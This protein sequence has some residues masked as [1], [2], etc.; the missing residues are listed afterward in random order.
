RTLLVMVAAL[1]LT[2]SAALIACGTSGDSS[3]GVTVSSCAA[4]GPEAHCREN[5]ALAPGDY[6]WKVIADDG[7]DG[8]Q[9]ESESR[10]FTVK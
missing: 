9:I 6:Q 5:L 3:S 1:S 4:A 8:G 7:R 10:S 2:S